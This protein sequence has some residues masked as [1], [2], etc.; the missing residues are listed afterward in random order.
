MLLGLSTEELPA[1][2]ASRLESI[3][4]L[5]SLAWPV[6]ILEEAVKR[7]GE[8]KELNVGVAI[9]L[10]EEFRRRV[11]EMTL[12]PPSREVLSALTSAEGTASG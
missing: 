7:L 12:N 1:S 8:G 2:L 5:S 3:P 11:Q 10:A 4:T 6:N 9:P